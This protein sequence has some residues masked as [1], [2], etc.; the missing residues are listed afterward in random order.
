MSKKTIAPVK[1]T[2]APVKK[3]TAPVKKT[4]APEKKSTV[5][6]SSEAKVSKPVKKPVDGEEEEDDDADW[7]LDDEDD[8]EDIEEDLDTIQDDMLGADEGTTRAPSEIEIMLRE[9]ECADCDGKR[10]P[11]KIRSEFHCPPGKGDRK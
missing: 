1:K 7:N 6:K 10:D 9:T 11:C 3:T 2:T 4:T 8:D 5:K